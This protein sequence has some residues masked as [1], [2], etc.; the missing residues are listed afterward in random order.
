MF[1]GL[2]NVYECTA[3]NKNLL[4]FCLF[5]AFYTF[6]LFSQPSNAFA[7]RQQEIKNY[8]GSRT[9]KNYSR[10]A[11]NERTMGKKGKKETKS[12]CGDDFSFRISSSSNTVQYMHLRRTAN[13]VAGDKVFIFP[14]SVCFLLLSPGIW[15]VSYRSSSRFI[16]NGKKFRNTIAAKRMSFVNTFIIFSKMSSMCFFFHRHS[17][18]GSHF[19]FRFKDRTEFSQMIFD[20]DAGSIYAWITHLQFDAAKLSSDEKLSAQFIIN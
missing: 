20:V 15:I 19:L 1:V 14:F 5:F 6:V 16:T 10:G 7:K 18:F 11:L 8:T 13:E 2:L 3:W 4:F 17:T 12:K 9:K